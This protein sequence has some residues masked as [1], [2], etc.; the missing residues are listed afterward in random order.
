MN[1]LTSPGIDLQT[2]RSIHDIEPSIWDG[3]CPGQPFGSHRWYAFAEKVMR[4]CRPF[5]TLAFTGGK[6]AGRASFYLTPSEPLPL[7]PAFVRHFAQ[8][9]FRRWPLMIERVP[10]AGLSGVTLP[11]SDARET[12]LSSLCQEAHELARQN[13][14]SF[15]FFDF[16]DRAQAKTPGWDAHFHSMVLSDPGTQLQITWPDFESYLTSLDKDSRYHYRRVQRKAAEAG[17]RV[18][19]HTT[20]T[21]LDDAIQLIR[22]V[23]QNHAS[24]PLPWTRGIL[25]N[26]FMVDG[27]WLTASI[28]DRLVGCGLTLRDN[29]AQIN[30]A[31]GLA[32]DV[33]YAYFALVYES[34]KLAT[35]NHVRLVRMGSGAYDVKRRLGF[36]L[37]NNNSVMAMSPNFI[38]QKFI[39]WIAL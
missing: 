38:L 2:Y 36:D 27:T 28:Q 21:C 22:L 31:L 23:E 5:Y 39:E 8:T 32:S 6:A 1:T 24:T 19:R 3:I 17:I 4:D 16:V 30:L 34:L 15:V 35:E 10:F 26:F 14:A 18:E 20:A 25:E 9:V 13:S 37:E 33:P 29:G 12:V 11:E 7:K